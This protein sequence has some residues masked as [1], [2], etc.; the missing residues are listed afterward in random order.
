MS[1][2][3]KF[4]LTVLLVSLTLVLTT[5]REGTSREQKIFHNSVVDN[6]WLRKG[7]AFWLEVAVLCIDLCIVV[8]CLIEQRKLRFLDELGFTAFIANPNS[9]SLSPFSTSEYLN[10][11]F[12][13]T[14]RLS[15]DKNPILT[16][17]NRSND[18]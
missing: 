8:L 3:D 18:L 13:T 10:S 4:K 11:C 14:E 16:I 7:W 9:Y 15:A 1:A 5:V 17:S 6:Y 12:E 2:N